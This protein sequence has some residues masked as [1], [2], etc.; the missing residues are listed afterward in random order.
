MSFPVIALGIVLIGAVTLVAVDM[1]GIGGGV[2]D[3]R[4]ASTIAMMALLIAI[5]GGALGRYQGQA[6]TALKHVAIWLAIGLGFALIY[7]WREPL[8]AA[9]GG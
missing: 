8:Q 9:F 4:F 3:P 6:G 1:L 5:G 7:M 2:T